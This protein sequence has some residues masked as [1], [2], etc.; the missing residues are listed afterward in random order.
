MNEMVP[1]Q[2]PKLE[3]RQSN[4]R[5]NWKRE[6]SNTP[7]MPETQDMKNAQQKKNPLFEDTVITPF[8]DEKEIPDYTVLQ[9]ATPED[10]KEREVVPKFKVK[11]ER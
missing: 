11:P 3:L 6:D 4:G 5:A 10:F 1:Q 7:V 8:K 2:P 9:K